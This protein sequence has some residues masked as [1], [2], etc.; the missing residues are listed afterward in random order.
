[1]RAALAAVTLLLCACGGGSGSTDE[2]SSQTSG[3]PDAPPPGSVTAKREWLPAEDLLDPAASATAPIENRFFVAV[4]AS[5]RALHV[6]QGR[7]SVPAGAMSGTTPD[8]NYGQNRLLRF[9][10]FEAEFI[11]VGDFLLPAARGILERA[12]AQSNWRIILSPGRAWSESGDGGWS[13]ASFPFVL[14][15]EATNEAHNGLA[16]FLFDDTRV[17][18]LQFQIVQET[19]SWSRNDFWGRLPLTYVPGVVAGDAE[20]RQAFAAELA[21]MTPV[22]PWSQLPAPNRE[23][24][25]QTFTRGLDSDD[26]SAGGIVK[27]GIVY[28]AACATRLGDYPY[29]EFMRHGAFSLT[30][31]MGAALTLLRLAQ[32][33]GDGVFD[34]P[35]R[36]YVNVTAGHDGWNEVRFIDILDMATGVGDANPN[37]LALDPLADENA[38][39]LG[40]WTSATGES[41]K[42]EAIF[43][44]GDY[45]WGPGEVFRYN[46]THTFVLAVAMDAFLKQ[47]EG[48]EARLWD[49]MEREVFAP[50]GMRH[51]P[52]M[53]TR[54]A[55]GTSGVPL[56]G[57]GL[58]PTV[59]DV[60][61][62]ATLLQNGGQ[63]GGEQLLSVR[64]LADA[65]FKTGR[66]LPT[67]ERNAAGAHLY[68]MSF[69][70]LP[71][72][73]PGRC[74]Q[75]IPYMEGYGGNFVVLMP[76]GLTAF[77]FADADI[78]DVEALAEVAEKIQPWCQ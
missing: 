44:Q 35:I 78:Y 16:T 76:N 60:A 40:A 71:H 14:V 15:C 74:V 46:T 8:S 25:W 30:K 69:W 59:D 22:R 61:K 37:P 66:G 62:I 20:L 53:H 47:M 73:T 49:M 50:I 21:A 36:D 6:L 11:T 67:G 31:S 19:A 56:M 27:D 3:V 13:R 75:H 23:A 10:G 9:P 28:Q 18:A 12:D 54:E 39:T 51:V 68:H 5:S 33:Y 52:M 43:R 70:S 63:H 29:C 42:L 1:M 58:Y 26:L 32:K 38:V 2:S 41:S 17:S 24:L 65:L 45:A 34:L 4:N 55:G 48:P 7:L 77:R 57:I 64:G 72:R